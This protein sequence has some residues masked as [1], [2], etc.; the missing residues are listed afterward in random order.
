MAIYL[1][2]AAADF[3]HPLAMLTACHE[4]IE[5][6]CETLQR[7]AAHLPVHGCDAQAQQAASNVMRYFDSAGRHHRE[8]EEQDLCPG[9]IAAAQGENAERI[10]LLVGHLVHEHNEIEKVWLELRDA[11]ENIAHGE[12]APLDAIAVSRFCGMYRTHMAMEEANLF[13]LAELLLGA[14]ALMALGKA[15]AKRRGVKT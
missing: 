15:M 6:Q 7:L 11:L 5:A 8:D 12:R 9:L 10:A 2:R 1:N 13:P 14:E 4:R 3:D